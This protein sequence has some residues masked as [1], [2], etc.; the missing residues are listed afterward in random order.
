MVFGELDLLLASHPA[1]ALSSALLAGIASSASPCAIAAVPLVVG[2]VGG[3]ADANR[4]RA[5]GYTLAFVLGMALT[6]T[7]AAVVMVTAGAIFGP[8]GPTWQIA[9]ALLAIVF[10]AHLLGIWRLP[11][12]GQLSCA[13]PPLRWRGALGAAI[14]GGLSGVV[15][16]PCAT[17]VLLGILSVIGSQSE[18]TFGVLLMF[19]YAVGHGALLLAAGSSIGFAQWLA[20]SRLAAGVGKTFVRLAGGL[21]L[22]YGAYLLWEVL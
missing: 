5:F 22:A 1:L 20:R 8:S 3:Y 17:P 21:L 16:V 13:M 14:A 2:Y 4:W 19:A 7:A 15:F 6:F 12:L 11:G 18:P 9:M 10:G